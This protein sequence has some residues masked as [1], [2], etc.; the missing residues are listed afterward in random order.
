MR[1]ALGVRLTIILLLFMIKNL[2]LK[3]ESTAQRI[4]V[5]IALLV[6]M[7]GCR[8]PAPLP[9]SGLTNKNQE[10]DSSRIE[11]ARLDRILG[12]TA[13]YYKFELHSNESLLVSFHA[14]KNNVD[15]KSDTFTHETSFKVY[16]K[17]DKNYPT[18][19]RMGDFRFLDIEILQPGHTWNPDLVKVSIRVPGFERYFYFAKPDSGSTRL[20]QKPWIARNEINRLLDLNYQNHNGEV[21][22]LTVDAEIRSNNKD[23]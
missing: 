9:K 3:C 19:E 20:V 2:F 23:K 14:Q 18:F 13:Q 15:V 21:H 5:V 10:N 4:V 6:L 22:T 12:I 7:T 8:T 11:I 16:Q 17:F 1:R